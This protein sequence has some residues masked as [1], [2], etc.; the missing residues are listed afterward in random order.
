MKKP[1]KK[2]VW[3]LFEQSG[4]FKNAFKEFGY[5][6]YDIDISND[7]K[8]TD[9]KIDLFAEIECEFEKIKI[10]QELKLD[11]EVNYND[12]TA[13]KGDYFVLCKDTIFD[14]ISK[15]DLVFAFFPCTHFTEKTSLNSR[16]ELANMEKKG[17][18]DDFS[19]LAYSKQI[20]SQTHNDYILL[21]SLCQIALA[22]GF[23]LIIENP[24]SVNP[25]FL[26]MYFPLKPTISIDDRSRYGDF[27]KKPTNFWFINFKPSYNFIFEN[28]EQKEI[29]N[30]E[31]GCKKQKGISLK[32]A[33]SLMSPE[34]ANRFIREFI[35]SE[36]ELNERVKKQ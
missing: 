15:D 16:C 12:F 28:C 11:K 27:Y 21:C 10:W 34:F 26:K 9:F 14:K 4:T 19:K 17:L 25:N 5:E 13:H 20:I 24:N 3:C 18:D 6:S 1:A 31:T 33:R 23:K 22:K 29:Y 7:F 32:V 30:I 8:Q 35:L 2:K 36:K